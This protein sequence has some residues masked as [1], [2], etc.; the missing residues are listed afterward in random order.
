MTDTS[1]WN[2]H[3]VV[4]G[5]ARSVSVGTGSVS[6]R[7]GSVSVA[8]GRVS[9]S[10]SGVSV[11]AGSI[12]VSGGAVAQRTAVAAVVAVATEAV[13]AAVAAVAAVASVAGM[14]VSTVV[15]RGGAVSVSRVSVSAVST[16]R[17]D[18]HQGSQ[19][20]QLWK[21]RDKHSTT[22]YCEKQASQSFYCFSL[23]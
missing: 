21:N 14:P 23:I 3:L 4:V 17:D 5:R 19:T 20:Q 15:G 6:V 12:S 16:S 11:A 10:A 7:A 2:A 22:A 13:A 1:R 18:S 9:V 8:T